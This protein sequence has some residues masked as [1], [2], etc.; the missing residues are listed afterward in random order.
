MSVVW[1][2]LPAYE[3][4]RVSDWQAV[5]HGV[6]R[7]LAWDS[8]KERYAL[9]QTVSIPKPPLPG[10]HGSSRKAREA[11][12]A[13]AAALAASAAAAAAS[14]KVEVRILLDDGSPNLLMKS[15]EGRS[16]PVRFTV[17]PFLFH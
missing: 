4:Y 8:C 12:A 14:A 5:D 10:K 9:L 11:A 3:I 16:E 7:H 13:H 17:R 15:I 6:A 1:P 2:E